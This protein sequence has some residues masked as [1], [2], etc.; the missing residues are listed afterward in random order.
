MQAANDLSELIK[1]AIS[2]NCIK[3]YEYKNFYN[4][5]KI[6]KSNSRKI[7]RTNLKNSEQ[8]FTLKSFDFDDITIKEIIHEFKLHHKIVHRNIIQFFGITD[9]ENENDQLEKYLLV[10][11]YVGD[12]TLQNYLKENYENLTW[13]N[14]YKLAYQLVCTISYLH[15]KE[16]VH[17]VLN[18][19][20][21][22]VYKNN[23]KL[24]D[25]GLSKRIKEA[26]NQHSDLVGMIPYIDPK[27]F[28]SI[29]PYSSNKKSDVYSIGV[30]LWELSSGQSPFKDEMYD[31][32]L[33]TQ[34]SQGYREKIVPNTPI[35]YSNLYTECWNC[36]PDDRPNMDQVIAK[37]KAIITKSNVIMEDYYQTDINYE[38]NPQLSINNQNY[39]LDLPHENLSQNIQNFDKINTKEMGPIIQNISKSIFEEDLSIIVD[40]LVDLYFKKAN[41]GKEE[42]IRRQAI[43]NCIDNYKLNS[44]EIY[45]WLINNQKKSNYIYLLGYFNYQGIEVESNKLKAFELYKKASDLNNSAA[46]YDLINMYMDGD[47]LCYDNG[48]G[49]E[50]NEQKAFEL[51]QMAANLENSHGLNNLACCYKNG[52]GTVINYQKAF[53][54]YQ[55]AADLG[56]TYGMYN[57]GKC[58]EK[59]I[60]VKKNINKSIYWYE[61]SAMQGH[62]NAQCKLEKLLKNMD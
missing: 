26:S 16:I 51:Y 31:A 43:F 36:E 39:N 34:I 23:I 49:I 32:N 41:E 10:T 52:L 28:V 59:G 60:L 8:Y 18:S 20:N 35:N 54:L 17:C 44:Q 15:D 57:L 42:M 33:A 22:L 14:K 48:I 61:K 50:A 13:E 11:E 46:Q 3:F 25:F 38:L 4:V 24:I 56:N 9:K 62:G 47:G 1:E 7:Y 6:G 45:N 5:E 40:E 53:E 21:I 12:I 2:S 27:K 58:Y 37:L 29:K 55:K 30:L 19:S